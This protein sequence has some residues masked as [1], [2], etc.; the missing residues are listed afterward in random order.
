MK[1]KGWLSIEKNIIK[2][3]KVKMPYNERLLLKMLG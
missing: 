3:G 2:C 1:S